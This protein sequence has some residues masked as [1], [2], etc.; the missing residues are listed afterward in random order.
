MKNILLT[1]IALLGMTVSSQAMSYEQ[2]RQKALFLADKMAY[3]LNLSEEQYEACYEVN[4]DYFMGIST[5]DDLYGDYWARRNLDLSYILL[6]WQYNMFLEASYFYRPLYWNSGNWHFGIYARYP[7]RDYFYFG[8]PYF[9]E[10]Y[11]GGHAWHVH[12][13][14]SW[15]HGRDFGFRSGTRNHSSGMRD[16]FNNGNYGRGGSLRDKG[17]NFRRIER[18]V[19]GTQSSTRLTAGNIEGMRRGTTDSQSDRI[20]FGGSRMERKEP[21][22]GSSNSTQRREIRS[23]DINS[24]MGTTN[25]PSSFGGSRGSS[26]QHNNI[27]RSLGIES[28]SRTERPIMQRESRSTIERYFNQPMSPS[29]MSRSMEGASMNRSIE[30]ASMSRSMGGS[31]AGRSVGSSRGG[32]SNSNSRGTFGG[33]RR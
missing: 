20:N 22:F 12:G 7:H 17:V 18:E 4:L 3:E 5:Y 28:M 25:H 24:N 15:Y 29:S 30:G 21:A 11:R 13:G 9:F 31:A 19:R 1:M 26:I 23:S 16:E 2:A 27:N 8:R 32:A 33:A 14:R 6:D 10:V